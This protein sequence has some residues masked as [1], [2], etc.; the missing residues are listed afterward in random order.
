MGHP[1]E[2][3]LLDQGGDGVMKKERAGLGAVVCA[4]KQGV[5]GCGSLKPVLPRLNGAPC[6]GP[7]LR[8]RTLQTWRFLEAKA[9]LRETEIVKQGGSMGY[10]RVLCTPPCVST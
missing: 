7:Q 5:Q 2:W 1:A 6:G 10:Q 8:S 9:L 4:L 3:L